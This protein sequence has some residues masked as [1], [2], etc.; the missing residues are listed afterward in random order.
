MQR[1]NGTIIDDIVGAAEQRGEA[2]SPS[3]R[4]PVVQ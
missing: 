3:V 1:S 2:I 4:G